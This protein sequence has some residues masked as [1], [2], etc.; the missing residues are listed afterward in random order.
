MRAYLIRE[1]APRR[2]TVG[3]RRLAACSAAIL[4]APAAW[5]A[6]VFDGVDDAAGRAVMAEAR[7]RIEQIR[8]GDLRLRVTGPDGAPFTGAIAIRLRRH[9]FLF[10]AAVSDTFQ[11]R[12]G[13]VRAT[14]EARAT[15]LAVA[16]ELFNVATVNCHWSTTQPAPEGPFSWAA[17]DALMN[18]ARSQGLAPRMHCLV[19]MNE[20]CAPRWHEQIRTEAEWW[21][22]IE[23]RIQAVA[24]RYGRDYIE[25][26]VLNE[27]NF[28][29]AW[30]REHNP[31]FPTYDAPATGVR[32]FQLARKYLPHARLLIL[33]Q[34]IP[35]TRPGNP[36]F[37]KYLAYCGQLL[38]A[39]A[40]VDAIGYQAHFYTGRPTF[41]AGTEQA[42]PDAFRMK[43][44][45]LGLDRLAAL[46][47]P[48]HITEFNP[49]SRNNK[50]S[51]PGQA[52]L[53]DDSVA[54][55]S[56]NFYTL[57]FSKPYIA[58]LTRWFVVD[59][60]GGRGSDAGLV[61]LDGRKKPEYFALKKLLQETWS[62]QWGGSPQ[63]GRISLRGFF[64][65]YEV[66]APGFRAVRFK[67][68]P[69]AP[70]F[71]EMEVRLEPL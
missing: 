49:P 69:A 41:A 29:G 64:G 23:R 33:D 55:W 42:G 60:L 27:T 9:A 19:Y 56:V 34:F 1:R 13:G 7:Q 2:A 53:T 46:G 70:T 39:G 6:E 11:V 40:P 20:G 65:E 43:E 8:Q 32:I 52:R 30:N 67:F 3:F 38:A 26:D 45:S 12:S 51:N 48:I 47:K 58:E 5:A 10:G 15:G 35:T 25:Y 66:T 28:L 68:E 59:D 54:S 63:A 71:A 4:L 37:E 61:T 17:S 22:L 50:V 36:G 31:G 44:L 21:P 57:A 62:T 18:W 24:E 16:A 14:P